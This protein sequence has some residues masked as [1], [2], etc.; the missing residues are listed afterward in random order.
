M[1]R[2]LGLVR[3]W[4]C[5]SLKLFQVRNP[6]GH[7]DS[8]GLEVM[9]EGVE[10]WNRKVM[11]WVG[12]GREGRRG[13]SHSNATD[14][15]KLPLSQD[16]PN[17]VRESWRGAGDKGWRDR[18]QGTASTGKGEIG[19][20]SWALGIPVWEGGEGLGILEFPAL[21]RLPLDPWQCPRPGWILLGWWEVTLDLDPDGI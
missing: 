8:A 1:E 7:G 17:P 19:L 18:T 3:L 4:G 11:E 5:N 9:V 13:S 15:G 14:Q 10:L 16:S 20:G 6:Y 2:L 12:L 21:L